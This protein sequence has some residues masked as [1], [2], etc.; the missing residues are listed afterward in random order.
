MHHSLSALHCRP[1]LIITII[2]MPALQTR[3]WTRCVKTPMFYQYATAVGT[4]L[5]VISNKRSFKRIIKRSFCARLKNT[6]LI[7]LSCK[8][9]R[10]SAETTKWHC[11]AL[12]EE[13]D[14]MTLP[15]TAR[16]ARWDY[17]T[18]HC[19]RSTTRLHYHALHKEHDEMTLPCTSRAAQRDDTAMHCTRSTTIVTKPGLELKNNLYL[20]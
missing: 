13:H 9:F 18:M 7:I 20:R 2:I 14:E 4:Q 1:L 8:R 11:H 3:T 16:G 15:C 12:H 19:T 5:N 17:T 6:D 10:R